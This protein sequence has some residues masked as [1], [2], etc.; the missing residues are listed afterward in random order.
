MVLRHRYEGVDQRAFAGIGQVHVVD[1]HDDGA[2][3]R[4]CGEGG[5]RG[6]GAAPI[7][8]A[9]LHAQRRSEL[10]RRRRVQTVPAHR[11]ES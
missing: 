9:S 7:V 10:R 1:Q 4:S 11:S 3:S 5:E 2:P 6:R 8:R